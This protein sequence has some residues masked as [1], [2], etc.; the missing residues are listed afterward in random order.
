M[1]QSKH[2]SKWGKHY[3][4]ASVAGVQ[5]ATEGTSVAEK[6]I[7]LSENVAVIDAIPE[8]PPVPVEEVISQVNA[9][10]EP[11]FVS[12]GLGGSTPVGFVQHCF[13]YLHVTLGIP[14][15]EAIVIGMLYLQ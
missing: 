15:W 3:A 7:D 1:R 12:L 5:V 10:G 13:E 6:P 4:V 14:W 8:A 2:F 11:T 9:L